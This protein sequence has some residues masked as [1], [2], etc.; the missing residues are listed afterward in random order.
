MKLLAITS[1]S[2]TIEIENDSP[3]YTPKAYDL[4]LNNVKMKSVTQNV[5]TIFDLVPDTEYQIKINEEISH[6]KTLKESLCLN[7]KDFYAIGDG[8]TD[9]TIKIMAAISCVPKNGCV[10]IPKGTYLISSLFLKSDMTLYLEEGARLIAKY[11]RQSF[12]VLPGEVGDFFYGTWEGSLVDGFASIV[13]AIECKNVSIVGQGEIDCQAH[14]GD[15]YVDHRT[16]RIAWRG[17]GM[18]FK[19]CENV[20]VIGVHIHNSPSWNVHPFFSKHL[21]FLNMKITNPPTIPTTDGL[22]PDCSEDCLIAGC[23][24]NVGDDCI[25]IKSGTYELAKRYKRSSKGIV[26]RNNLMEQG[27]GGVVFGSESSGGISDVTVE[28]CIFRHT[29]RGFRIK[30]RRGRGRIA[31]INNVHF[32]HILMDSVK[33]PF[34]INMYYNMG[35]SGGHEEYVSS[36]KALLVDEY[37]PLLGCFKFKHMECRDVGYAA[38]VFLGLPEAKIKKIELED[39]SFSY[40]NNCEEGYPVMIEHNFKLKNAGII[41]FNVEEISC[42]Q[43]TFEGCNG[44]HIIQKDSA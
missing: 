22:D 26:I 39:V 6:I 10:Y 16:K 28:K 34:V 13:N 38:G 21:K 12:P 15:W 41:A 24:F 35:S 43:V 9:D 14:L 1:R 2:I 36:T 37:T 25:A 27:H 33:T 29:D 11:D 23:Y 8:K 3:Y 18:Y 31:Q 30:T 7:V 40:D 44:E 5:F 17:F 19:E 32:E 20:S 42:N 4:F